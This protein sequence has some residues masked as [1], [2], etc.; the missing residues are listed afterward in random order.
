[1]LLGM[2]AASVASERVVS[3]GGLLDT[4]RRNRLTPSVFSDLLFIA[5]HAPEPGGV[6]EFMKT[7]EGFDDLMQAFVLEAQD[8]VNE[9]DDGDDDDDI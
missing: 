9:D 3:A 1:M 2:P 7:L 4:D 6:D 8:G 5:K